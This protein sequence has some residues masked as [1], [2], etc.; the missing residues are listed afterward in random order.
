MP[1]WAS[2]AFPFNSDLRRM[3]VAEKKD[4]A[5]IW[6]GNKVLLREIVSGVQRGVRQPRE[7]SLGASNN[8]VFVNKWR[9]MLKN[10]RKKG[11]EIGHRQNF[12]KNIK[13]G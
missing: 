10:K 2:H 13:S 11:Y 4:N 12:L 8:P 9:K 6:R 5:E 3:T 1:L 7:S